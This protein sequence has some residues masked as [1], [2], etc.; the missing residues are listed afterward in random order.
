MIELTKDE[1]ECLANHLEYYIIQ[2]LRDDV[3][4]DSMDYL[5][6]LTRISEKCRE[7]NNGTCD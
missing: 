2:E 6:K 3:D 1:A 5:C 4:Y 7:G